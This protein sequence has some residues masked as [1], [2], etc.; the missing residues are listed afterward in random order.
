M[1]PTKQT[2][3]TKERKPRRVYGDEFKD[4]AVRM[5]TEQKYKIGDAARSLGIDRSLLATWIDKIAP[6]WQPALEEPSNDPVVLKVQLRDA[7]QE[8]RRLRAAVDVLKKATAYFANP[9][10]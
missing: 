1:E 4:G 2:A 5:V 3:T 8:V 7:L 6:H 10:P 9:N